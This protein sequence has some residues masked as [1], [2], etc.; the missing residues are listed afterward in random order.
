MPGI[1]ICEL[2]P[3]PGQDRRQAGHRPQHA[4]PAAATHRSPAAADTAVPRRQRGRPA[5]ARWSASSQRRQRPSAAALRQRWRRRRLRSDEPG[6]PRHGPPAVHARRRGPGQPR[7]A[8]AASR[9]DRLGRPPDAAARVRHAAPRPGRRRGEPGRHGRL[10]RPGPGDDQ[11]DRK[12][13]D[14]FDLSREPDRVR[15]RYGTAARDPAAPAAWCEAGAA[16]RDAGRRPAVPV[17]DRC[18]IGEWDHARSQLP[19]ACAAAA[20]VRP[21]VSTPWSRDLHER[22][23]DDDVARGHLGRDRPHAARSPSNGTAAAATT[24]RRPASR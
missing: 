9:L 24:G 7:P 1:D 17:G 10:H 16:G 2:L 13:R 11:L 21:G 5:S 6:L 18:S 23:L 8:H 20:A 15:E 19:T 22:G 4:V 3:L 14:A 12:A